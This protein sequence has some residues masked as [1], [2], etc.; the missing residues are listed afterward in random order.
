MEKCTSVNRERNKKTLGL[1]TCIYWNA[2]YIFI[3]L[4][5]ENSNHLD[6][7][8]S[9]I[10]PAGW[11]TPLFSYL[12]RSSSSVYTI[13]KVSCQCQVL[14][15]VPVHILQMIFL[16][17]RNKTCLGF[18]FHCS[19]ISVIASVLLIHQLYL[20]RLGIIQPAQIVKY[21]LAKID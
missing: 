6:V 7:A 19:S 2:N 12:A 5:W 8:C 21:S 13:H 4:G 9:I 14:P 10:V 17:V 18:V 16:I 20:P 15:I 11:L 1:H 3:T